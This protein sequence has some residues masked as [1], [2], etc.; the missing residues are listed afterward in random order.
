MLWLP[1]NAL[2]AEAQAI[3]PDAEH[4]VEVA[5][6]KVPDLIRVGAKTRKRSFIAASRLVWS[7][8][9]INAG[10]RG[11][12]LI[13]QKLESLR[14]ADLHKHPNNPLVHKGTLR[15]LGADTCIYLQARFIY[16]AR[17]S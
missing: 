3:D 7:E 17:A 14:L 11:T 1:S 6:V 4:E 9:N 12:L 2:H 8:Q 13:K 5:D 16:G 10:A 15:V